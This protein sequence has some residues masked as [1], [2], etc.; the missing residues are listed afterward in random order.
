MRL[1]ARACLFSTVTKNTPIKNQQS[2]H[3]RTTTIYT[4]SKTKEE[5]KN[6]LISPNGN[7][8]LNLKHPSNLSNEVHMETNQDR[9]IPI[10]TLQENGYLINNY[11]ALSHEQ[12]LDLLVND[13]NFN[14]IIEKSQT[15]SS[16]SKL[17]EK[18]SQNTHTQLLSRYK[19]Y[20]C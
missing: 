12:F 7:Y 17:I 19:T 3:K 5:H 14:E 11:I 13:K 20:N 10:I 9:E 16:T 8:K 6:I 15:K 18:K 2:P 1:D 4:R